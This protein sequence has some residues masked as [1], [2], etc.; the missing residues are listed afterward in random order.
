MFFLFF[1]ESLRDDALNP[2][3][4]PFL[5]EWKEKECQDLG[6]TWAAS[7]VTHQSWFSLLSGRLPVFMVE[8]R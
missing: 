2:E 5:S 4:A 3:I 7:N 6:V 1:V 8:A